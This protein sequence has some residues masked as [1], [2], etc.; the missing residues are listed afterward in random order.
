MYEETT[1]NSLERL[2]R[3]DITCYPKAKP[4]S[5]FAWKIVDKEVDPKGSIHDV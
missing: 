2:A 3:K 1:G 5:E 4:K